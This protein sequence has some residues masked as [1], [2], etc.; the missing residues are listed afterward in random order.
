M[1]RYDYRCTTCMQVFELSRPMTAADDTAVCP[2][3]HEGATRLLA[4]FATT[5][6]ATA[7][8]AAGGCCGGGCCS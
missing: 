2:A 7:P 3:G 8:V 5:G 6:G 4:V 1:A